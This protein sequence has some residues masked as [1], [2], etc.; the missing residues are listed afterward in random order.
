MWDHELQATAGWGEIGTVSMQNCVTIYLALIYACTVTQLL[1]AME[2]HSYIYQNY[3]KI[4]I[5]APS[6]IAKLGKLP[7]CP[8]ATE[9]INKSWC[10]STMEYHTAKKNIK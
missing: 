1:H 6:T 9:E 2:M 4:L 8:S 5:E 3:C 7:K 10:I